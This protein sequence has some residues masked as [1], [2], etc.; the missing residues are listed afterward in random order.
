MRAGLFGATAMI[1]ALGACEAVPSQGAAIPSAQTTAPELVANLVATPEAFSEAIAM[2]E[3]GDTIFLANGVWNDFDMLVEGAGTDAAPITVRAQTPGE[4]ILSGQSSLRLAGEH[5]VVSGLVFR[6][7]YTPR[8]E[9][10][11]FRKDSET[12]A[13]NSRVT[14]TVID[15]YSNPDR[16]QRDIWVMMYGQNNVFDRNHLEGKQNSGPT[17]A[18]RLNSEE[19]QENNHLIAVQTHRHGRAGILLSF[20]VVSVEHIVLTVHHYPD[21]ALA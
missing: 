10:I 20:Q 8:S 4:V 2:A 12:L 3:P 19:S 16:R 5:L 13:Y 11:S 14:E 21:V 15:N 6:D 1:L 9:V 7:G 18:V 17:M